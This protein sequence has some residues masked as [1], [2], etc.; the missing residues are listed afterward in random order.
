M[1]EIA[2]KKHAGKTALVVWLAGLAQRLCNAFV[3]WVDAEGSMQNE[4]EEG[5]RFRNG[6]AEKLG[7]DMASKNFYCVQPKLLIRTKARKRGKKLTKAGE[8]FMQPAEFLFQEAEQVA[9]S[10]KK[11]YP[12]RP[13]FWALDSIANLITEAD[14]NAGFTD[15]N[16]RTNNDR[17]LFLSKALPKM[18]NLG[19][20]YDMWLFLI[21]QIRTKPGVMFGD[22]TYTPGGNALEHN[23]H[24]QARIVR[25][26]KLTEVVNGRTIKIGGKISNIK[27]KA[28]GVS[29][30][31]LQCGY[32]VGFN[33][34]E[35]K[36]WRFSPLEE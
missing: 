15:S 7:L 22:P 17:A 19:T 16:M 5:K 1:Y 28:G 12:D 2:G 9:H 11:R 25:S 31:G 4:A 33:R 35:G 3:I 27:N 21:N 32:S 14:Y 18:V 13:I 24:I 36:M 34:P 30:E 20:N 26:K 8:T 23:C 10:I 29:V 6:W